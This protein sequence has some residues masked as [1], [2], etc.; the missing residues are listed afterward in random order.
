MSVGQFASSDTRI[1]RGGLL[2]ALTSDSTPCV[3]SSH[4]RRHRLQNFSRI[5]KTNGSCKCWYITSADV[6]RNGVCPVSIF[7]SIAPSEY[8]SER[9]STCIPANCSGLAKSG[10]PAKIPG[11]EIAV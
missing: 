3:D 2:E 6:P 8:R 5:L 7:Q 11:I 4:Y 10:V 1:G 9:M